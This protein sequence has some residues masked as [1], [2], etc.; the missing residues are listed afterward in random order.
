CSVKMD[1]HFFL[2]Q[3][4]FS[5]YVD[6]HQHKRRWLIVGSFLNALVPIIY[7]FATT[8]DHVYFAQIVLGVGS[9]LVFPTWLS[10]WSTH[11]DKKHEAFEWSLYSTLTGVGAAIVASIGA[12]VAD[13]FGFQITFML[14]S[15]LALTGCAI[16]FG[17]NEEKRAR[18]S[19]LIHVAVQ[20]HRKLTHHRRHG[21]FLRC[22]REFFLCLFYFLVE[23]YF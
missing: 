11:L 15:V 21:N 16:L 19:P 8:I 22:E 10:L 18:S 17:L 5:K 4:P 20:K 13:I 3:L 23:N 9:G 7:I 12:Y 14:V 1:I 2:I 6:T